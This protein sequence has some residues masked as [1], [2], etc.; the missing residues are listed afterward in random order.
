VLSLVAFAISTTTYAISPATPEALLCDTKPYI[1]VG[2]V[3]SAANKHCRLTK[4]QAQCP[5]YGGNDVQLE[6]LVI[7]ILGVH[8]ETAKSPQSA[9]R[10]GQIIRPMTSA[11]ASPHATTKYDGQG[12]LTFK[13]PQ[14][15]ILPD[16]WLRTAYVGQEFV[17]SGGAG[18]VRVWPLEKADW[19]RETMATAIR[20]FRPGYC[21]TPL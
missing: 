15:T 20:F 10:E 11:L 14:D 6:V 12:R 13:A 4:S 7:R 19:A 21:H 3:L 16:E 18:S 5:T 2:R 8:P 17:F 1:F 9:L